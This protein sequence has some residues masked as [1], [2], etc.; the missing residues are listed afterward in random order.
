MQILDCLLQL[1]F[2]FFCQCFLILLVPSN[3]AP[4]YM[5][6]LFYIKIVMLALFR[7]PCTQIPSI[8]AAVPSGVDEVCLHTWAHSLV[9][10]CSKLSRACI[11]CSINACKTHEKHILYVRCAHILC[12]Q[13]HAPGMLFCCACV[14][15]RN[16]LKGH[17]HV[18]YASYYIPSIYHI[19]YVR[20]C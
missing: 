7:L 20:M 16:M 11:L 2:E 13:Q 15:S 12:L 6:Y 18:Q 1:Y 5:N 17:E 10:T 14:Y 3:R 8:D 19:W 4:R 9:K